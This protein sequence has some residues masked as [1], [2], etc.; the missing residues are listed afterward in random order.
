MW[1]QR[2]FNQPRRLLIAATILIVAGCASS[3]SR[4]DA[5]T[6]RGRAGAVAG[7]QQVVAEIP[8]QALTMFEQA[9]SIMASGDFV[10]A[11]LRFKEFLLQYPGYPGAHVNLAIIHSQNGNDAAAQ[12]AIDAA[13][14]L[15]A[16]HPAA[17]NQQGMLFRKNGKFIEAE[18]AY[19]KAVTA[20]PE[21]ALAH[22]NLGVLNE[23]YLQRLDVALQ[24]FETYQQLVGNDA[25]VE[26]WIADL[27][28]RVA[29][30]QRTANVAE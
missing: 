16:V 26:K 23:L 15:N 21:Y 7:M 19:L 8:P 20:S 11:E 18:A 25:Q 4:P 30:N 3:G 14:A 5:A 27:T 17:L 1:L 13:L 22:Y 9:V 12:A 24:H 10:D 29:A 2:Y 28:R 6:D